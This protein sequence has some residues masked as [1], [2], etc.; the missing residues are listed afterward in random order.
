[1]NT[2][3]WTFTFLTWGVGIIGFMALISG[4]HRK[5]LL[6]SKLLELE[7]YRT[8]VSTPTSEMPEHLKVL[9]DNSANHPEAQEIEPTDELIGIIFDGAIYPP[10]LDYEQS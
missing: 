6:Q 7:L 1:M 8:V 3:I 9:I 5:S 2:L 10:D 4:L